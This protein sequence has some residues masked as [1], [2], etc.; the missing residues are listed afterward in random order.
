MHTAVMARPDIAKAV[1]NVAWFMSNLSK[2]HMRA[3]NRIWGYLKG[4]ADSVLTL[5]RRDWP[6]EPNAACDANHANDEHDSRSTSGYAI[7]LGQGCFSWSA[8]RQTKIAI[9]TGEAEYYAAEH[10]IREIIWVRQMLSE[11]GLAPST[12][13]AMVLRTDSTS[14]LSMLNSP[15]QTSFRTK[16]IRL[17]HHWVREEVR[18]KE[19]VV[20]HVSGEENAAD[21]FTK[22]LEGPRHEKLC[23]LLGLSRPHLADRI[24]AEGEC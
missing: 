19:V 10:C 4:T 14:A 13:S 16:H 8:K 3:L 9:S 21:I 12:P 1:Q 7:F 22:G 18:R 11:V 17:A 5:G 20:E 24:L 6:I 2:A 15:D 23:A